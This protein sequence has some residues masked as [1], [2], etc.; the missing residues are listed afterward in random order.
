VQRGAD[1]AETEVH[2]VLARELEE[3]DFYISQGLDDEAG[4]L[5]AELRERYGDHPAV[6]ERALLMQSAEKR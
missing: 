1:E 4:V 3:L 2:E 6:R 5:V